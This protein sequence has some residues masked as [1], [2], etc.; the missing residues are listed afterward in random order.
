M[1]TLTSQIV[2]KKR[3]LVRI[4]VDVELAQDGKTIANDFKLRAQL[5]TIEWLVAKGAKVI[6][7]GHFGRP[8]GRV[9]PAYSLLPVAKKFSELLEKKIKFLPS[10]IGDEVE[11]EALRMKEG[12]ILL[13]ENLRF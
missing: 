8:E 9:D 7:A 1:K 2:R 5:P 4:D 11:D 3:V 10:S 6:L 13:L 12:D